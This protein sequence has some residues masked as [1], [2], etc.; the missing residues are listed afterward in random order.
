MGVQLETSEAWY[1][2]IC[3]LKV[4]R[5]RADPAPHKP[6][7]LLVFLD[8][9]EENQIAGGV[10]ELTPALAFRF[11]VYGSVVAYRRSQPLLARFPFFHLQ[12]DGFW[13]VLDL[14]RFPTSERNRAR[15]ALVDSVF[16]QAASDPEFR[17][18]VRSLLIAKYFQPED[19]A[20][21]YS[22]C[23]MEVPA[24][25]VIAQQAGYVPIA[26]ASKKG[27]D[28]RFRI[29][30]VSNYRFTCALTGYRL[31]TISSETIVD[32]AHIHEFSSSRNDDPRNGMALC[33]NAHWMFDNGLWSLGD[34]YR[35]I[36]ARGHFDE[37]CRDPGTKGLL[38]HE[39]ATIHLPPDP[40]LGP[41]IEHLR[42]HRKNRFKGALGTT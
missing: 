16:L 29:S 36:V 37:E 40:S 18:R 11:S 42:W 1:G 19:R 2:K 7:L 38:D 32:A 12:S 3:H 35:V 41:D 23:R 10:M 31:T 5:A 24:E 30:V 34:D 22:L 33:K 13:R 21:L 27:R 25:D 6:L 8:L 26:E 14:N 20:A 15:F 28:A 39:G 9:V 4:D 17:Q